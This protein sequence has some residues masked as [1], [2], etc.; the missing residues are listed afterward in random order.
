M[1][2][3]FESHCQPTANHKENHSVH[4]QIETING[5]EER[6]QQLEALV[7]EDLIADNR[8]VLAVDMQAKTF[9]RNYQSS[10]SN[11]AIRD[12]KLM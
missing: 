12:T 6:A 3:M 5:I 1:C 4:H 11:A 9:V 7:K 10:I 8:A 2:E